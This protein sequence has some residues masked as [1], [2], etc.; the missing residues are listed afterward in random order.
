MGLLGIRQCRAQP[1][2]FVQLWGSQNGL[3]IP[4]PARQK[5]GA[6][7]NGVGKALRGLRGHGERDGAL[8]GVCQR[9]GCGKRNIKSSG[10]V[11]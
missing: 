6:E 10:R 9:L 5:P 1:L 7:G 4:S 11:L 2:D 3:L 8:T